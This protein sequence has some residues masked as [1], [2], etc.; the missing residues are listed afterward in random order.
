MTQV[1]HLAVYSKTMLYAW[2]V[3]GVKG[4]GARG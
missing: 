1:R 3:T 2:P 4:Y